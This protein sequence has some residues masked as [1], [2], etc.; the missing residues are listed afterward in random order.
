MCARAITCVGFV[1]DE[2]DERIPEDI[3]PYDVG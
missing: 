1:D 3:N 2:D